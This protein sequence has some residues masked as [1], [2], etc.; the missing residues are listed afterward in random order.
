[1]GKHFQQLHVHLVW[2]TV[3]RAP[4]L[5]AEVALWLWP[6]IAESARAVGSGFVVVGGVADHVHVLTELPVTVSVSDLVRRLKGASS[7]LLNTKG[8]ASAGWQE[9]Y[10]VFA[11]GRDHLGVVE[12]Y[13]RNQDQ[14]H[15]SQNLRN[16]FETCE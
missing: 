4:I 11:V 13:V 3:G 16:E 15:A 10:G 7:R 12:A 1:M 6:T 8:V 2:A 9:G 5:T 14:H